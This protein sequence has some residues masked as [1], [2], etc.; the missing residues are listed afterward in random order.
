MREC[1]RRVES[2]AETVIAACVN[3]MDFKKGGYGYLCGKKELDVDVLTVLDAMKERVQNELKINFSSVSEELTP[4]P[5]LID[6]GVVEEE[7]SKG[8]FESAIAMLGEASKA[9]Y[10][11]MRKTMMEQF[12]I[13][14]NTL[15][16]YYMLTKYWPKINHFVVR[17]LLN[18][19]YS[20]Q[21]NLGSEDLTS[22][23]EAVLVPLT[24]T[25][26]NSNTSYDLSSVIGDPNISLQEAFDQCSS[27]EKAGGANSS[28]IDGCYDD[29]ILMMAKKH[30]DGNRKLQGSVIVMDSYDGDEHHRRKNK[31][32]YY[33]I[34]FPNFIYNNIGIWL[35][36]FQKLQHPHM[37]A[38]VGCRVC[39]HTF[40]CNKIYF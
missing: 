8:K 39:T 10:G 4:P 19:P 9:G 21:D 27:S 1:T 31:K 29:Y 3:K 18:R 16:S 28:R 30:E 34:Q 36:P 15:T 40:S 35:I 33:I 22:L 2:L 24:S 25:S 13:P 11:R 7:D 17:P 12:S 14:D 32:Q 20:E 23:P 37:A 5:T 38:N 26:I 6:E